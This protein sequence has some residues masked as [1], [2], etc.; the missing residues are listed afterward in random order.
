MLE[1]ERAHLHDE[2]LHSLA[3]ERLEST[4]QLAYRRD[5][6][7]DE[8]E[9]HRLRRGRRLGDEVRGRALRTVGDLLGEERDALE[10]GYE[11]ARELEALRRDVDR[12]QRDAGDV[13]PGRPRLA[14][15]PAPTGSALAAI[16]IG[17]VLV[18]FIAARVP[19]VVA[20]TITSTSRRTSA[21]ASAGRR[22]KS[23][24]A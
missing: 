8:L 11:L 5:L 22:E 3:P 15:R 16:T 24:P 20:V 9:A 2:R 13:A 14:T 18:A 19:A 21:S 12:L 10:A 23:L 17:I 1:Q 4:A 7:H 6:A